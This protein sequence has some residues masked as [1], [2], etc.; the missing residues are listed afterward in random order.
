LKNSRDIAL[1]SWGTFSLFALL[2]LMVFGR[3]LYIQIAQAGKWKTHAAKIEQ[4][5]QD[6]EPAR[7]QIY[8]SDGNLLATSVPVYNLYWDSQADGI[9]QEYFKKEIDS[10]AIKLSQILRGGS[11]E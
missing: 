1:R 3:I 11:P 8:S 2:T 4:R 9:N 5:I 6:I 10:L 7:G